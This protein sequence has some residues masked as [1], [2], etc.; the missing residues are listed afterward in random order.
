VGRVKEEW[1]RL[2]NEKLH[3]LYSSPNV[4]RVIKIRNNYMG[5]AFGTGG[6]RGGAY[7]VLVEK[8]EWKQ[9]IRRTRHKQ[10]DNT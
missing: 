5:V 1:R 6:G 2:H 4:I 9:L 10:E 3:V 8:R 7:R